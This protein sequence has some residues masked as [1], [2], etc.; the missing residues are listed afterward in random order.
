MPKAT[1]VIANWSPGL[2]AIRRADVT[3]PL[4]RHAATPSCLPS[5]RI[6]IGFIAFSHY[7]LKSD[8]FTHIFVYR[9]LFGRDTLIF[10]TRTLPMKTPIIAPVC[11]V[12]TMRASACL[13]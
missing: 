6:D 2:P 1:S 4:P 13:T 3:P 9:F 7:R 11:H 12:I 8:E 5:D 10:M